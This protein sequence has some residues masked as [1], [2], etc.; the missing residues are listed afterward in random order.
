MR[1]SV[2]LL[3][4]P[5]LAS[6]VA[7][8]VH[9]KSWRKTSAALETVLRKELDLTQTQAELHR[10]L[11]ILD[12]ERSSLEYTSTVLDHAGKERMRKLA[13]YRSVRVEREQT[14]RDRGRS[15]YK[16]ARGG[17][18]RLAFEGLQRDAQ[19]DS[20]ARIVR[21]RMLRFL[22][23]HDLEELAIHRR[24][25]DRASGELVAASRELQSLSAM[26]TV[27]TMQGQVLVRAQEALDPELR[28][29]I[30]KRRRVARRADDKA[31]RANRALLSMVKSNWRELR[32]LR[33]L[34][35]AASL[36]R[37]VRGK[38][39][40][41]FGEYED[42]V[43]RLPMVRNGVEL[44]VRRNE[45]VRAMA[46]GRVVLVTKLPGY[47]DVVVIDHGGGQYTLTARLWDIG[48]EEG[49]EVEGGELLGRVASKTL[50]DGLGS[51]V[52][53][54]L[55][56]GEKPVDPT[57]YLKRARPDDE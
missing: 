32:S 17:V 23:Q 10:A 13:A 35:G 25:E 48:V 15:L 21:G 18:A 26:S 54:E 47:E 31:N 7:W 2:A 30:R 43:L 49:Q 24:A 12:R 4:V 27:Q 50:D 34:D 41:V 36:V 57:A 40:G 9:A 29:T 22:V 51:T 46:D 6:V 45:R 33:G 20:S 19:A 1:R 16:L 56:H 52:Y 14:A 39:V 42:K 53:I 8:P 37:P 11:T 44:A 3:V 28:S 38:A 5:A 55:R